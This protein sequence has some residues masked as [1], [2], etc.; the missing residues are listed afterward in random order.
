MDGTELL[1]SIKM[2]L[3][4]YAIALPFDN[5]NEVLMD[6]IRTKT[7]KTFSI[8]LPHIQKIRLSANDMEEVM[9][10]NNFREYLLPDVFGGMK[11]LGVNSV[12]Y[13]VDNYYGSGYYST[14]PRID[15]NVSN[16]TLATASANLNRAVAQPMTFDFRHPRTLIVYD[17]YY[18]DAFVIELKLEH[19]KN[20]VTIPPMAEDSFLE[21]AILDIKKFLYASLK[22]YND[23]SS[24]Y[25]NISLKIDD[26]A[27]A[28]SDRKQLLEEWNNLY[29]TE[30]PSWEWG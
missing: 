18:S 16:I 23:L 11:L 22:H 19:S 10:G 17:N 25:G 3:G 24:A 21:L 8:F 13:N 7:L 14:I 15:V 5:P 29:Y 1:T 28:E 30:L 12:T 6:V 20:L 26:W 4:I 27:N 9:R 2:E